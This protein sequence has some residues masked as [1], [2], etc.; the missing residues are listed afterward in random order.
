[1]VHYQQADSLS[2]DT[3][4][5]IS[6]QGGNSSPEPPSG[7]TDYNA[8]PWEVVL[9][10]VLDIGIPDRTEVTGQPWLTI[11]QDG[12]GNPGSHLIWSANWNAKQ[13]SGA[14]S[15][16]VYLNPA[17]YTAG[18]PWDRFLNAPA[19]T[20]LGAGPGFSGLPLVPQ[21]F[22]DASLELASLTSAMNTVAQ[23]FGS[24]YNSVTAGGAPFNGNVATV[25]A[26]LFGGLNRVTLNLYHQLSGPPAYSDSVGAAGGAATAFLADLRSAYTAW[27]QLTEHSPLGAVVKV[28]TEIAT[29]DG[30]GGYT[31]PDPQNTPY[32]D[33]TTG[34]A[35]AAVEQQ[36]KN[37]WLGS[38]TGSGD[39][40]GLD[41]LGQT[42]LSKLT[43]QYATTTAT[44]VPVTGPGVPAHQPNP[45][46]NGPNGQNGPKGQNGPNG[47][48]GNPNGLNGP[49]GPNG[50]NGNPG[51]GPHT[52]LAGGGGGGGGG[53]P[54]GNGAT[55][56]GGGPTTT[57]QPGGPVPV[58]FLALGNPAG[59]PGS[60][61]TG[62]TAGP[63]AEFF[64][65][66]L[67]A[68]GAPGGP[69]QSGPLTLASGPGGAPGFI[70]LVG[71]A[72][73][74]G[75]QTTQP[76]GRKAARRR[77][78]IIPGAPGV[79]SGAIGK[80]GQPGGT[81]QGTGGK[82]FTGTIGLPPGTDG[83][84]A[85]GGPA[86]TVRVVPAAGFSL[87]GSPN[88]AVLQQSAVPVIPASSSGITSGPINTQLT[89]GGAGGIPGGAG[90]TPGG[91]A[92]GVPGTQPGAD[93]MMMLPP[94]GR[95]I[96]AG[97]G[98]QERERLAYLPEAQESWGT[99]PEHA[100]PAVGADLKRD[101]SEPEFDGS[102]LVTAIGVEAT[103]EANTQ[104]GADRRRR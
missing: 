1:M 24:L 95:G 100:P 74:A 20:M 48:N 101:A 99:D 51:G 96:G 83:R 64:V 29:P 49:N 9:A 91:G 59:G 18:G 63:Q 36:A 60:T 31:I 92:G 71:P 11:A 50:Q 67:T 10:T 72:G 14:A 54:S 30:N 61:G 77:G 23:Q 27:S 34:A 37:V 84:F 2:T 52:F 66:G 3:A 33:L 22:Q 8:W 73:L 26:E 104:S 53:G 45:V 17:L 78:L 103:T 15:V 65:P 4:V 35:W 97:Q 89:P 68:L 19:D 79:L 38:L 7:G 13:N 69:G 46:G 75:L 55:P 41:L 56:P 25:V 76:N 88:G 98:N 6:G 43:G 85:A 40:G 82:G 93:R 44:V 16:Q 70:G 86:V 57:G 81:G 21:T 12:S 58:S 102:R 28:L 62:P 94:V 42:A 47:P 32:G 90:V 80:T 39:F 87:G 5:P